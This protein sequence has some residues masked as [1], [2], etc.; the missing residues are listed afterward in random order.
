MRPFSGV[1]YIVRKGGGKL[2]RFMVIVVYCIIMLTASGCSQ[3]APRD[4]A[5]E[6]QRDTWVLYDSFSSRKGT[7]LFD[8]GYLCLDADLGGSRL[9]LCEP[10]IVGEDTI[11]IV[12][13]D[14][15]GLSMG[16]AL[17]GDTLLLTLNGRSITW[18]KYVGSEATTECP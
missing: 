1:F 5:E 4:A 14:Y 17:S 16:Y 15:A 11:S 8:E 6:L 9:A 10:C 18:K 13:S 7:L 12:S 2:K 3:T